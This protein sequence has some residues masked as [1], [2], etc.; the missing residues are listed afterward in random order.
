MNGILELE[1]EFA[2]LEGL[3]LE[4]AYS[5][6]VNDAN[7][8]NAAA[9]LADPI[10]ESTRPL[11]VCLCGSTKFRAAFDRAMLDETLA[12][13]IVL[14]IGRHTQSDAELGAQITPAIKAQ[15]DELHLQKI[16][17]ADE[18]LVLNV[19]GYVGASTRREVWF[20]QKLGKTVRWL[21]P[22]VA[23]APAVMAAWFTDWTAWRATATEA[24]RG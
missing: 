19:D 10:I 21:E 2:A 13:K 5:R 11:I 1:H 12:G 18:V 3:T 17:L 15:L 23:P 9:R 14:S 7:R 8:V 4:K 6:G 20:A 22:L 16:V 24:A